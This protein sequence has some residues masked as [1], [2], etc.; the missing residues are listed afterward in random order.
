MI[1]VQLEALRFFHHFRIMRIHVSN[2][3]HFTVIRITRI[4]VSNGRHFIVIRCR[5]HKVCKDKNIDLVVNNVLVLAGSI[6]NGH[7]AL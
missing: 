5:V 3:R 2:G 1:N 4:H 7:C 6:S